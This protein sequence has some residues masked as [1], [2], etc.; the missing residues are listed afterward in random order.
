MKLSSA[1]LVLG[2]AALAHHDVPHHEHEYRE[3]IV[4]E[5]ITNM[6]VIGGLIHKKPKVFRELMGVIDPVII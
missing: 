2:S 1:L 6:K 4:E 3:E 5:W